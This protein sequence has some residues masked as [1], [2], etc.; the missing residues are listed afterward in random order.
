MDKQAPNR[1]ESETGS[2]R[3]Y[4]TSQTVRRAYDAICDGIIAGRYRPGSHLR[5]VS[6]AEE[7]GV[8]RTP[9]REA[10]RR[11]GAEGFVE[12]RPNQGTFVREWSATSLANIA[13]MRGT[14]GRAAGEA[15][16]RQ[17][18]AEDI[19][20]LT[21]I[22][23][24]MSATMARRKADD[25]GGAAADLA[26]CTV[27][28]ASHIFAMAG[29]DW[30]LQTIRQTS[31]LPTIR[32]RFLFMEPAE[33]R[34]LD[35]YHREIVAALSAQDEVWSGAMVEG[36]FRVTKHMSLAAYGRA[37]GAIEDGDPEAETEA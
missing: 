9:V 25:A 28:L 4:A 23:D 21:G 37:R 2:E 11:L 20:V 34:R 15:A 26:H 31:D 18:T 14:L 27:A 35:F 8:S 32:R 33:W 3:L 24:E 13:D 10:L 30:M 7:I 22:V 29:N 17:T 1:Q 5:E 6:L 19:E 12:H 36:Y 16:A